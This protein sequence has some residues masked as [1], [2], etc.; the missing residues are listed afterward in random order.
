MTIEFHCPH[1]DKTLK[2]SEDKAGRQAKCPG[3]GELITVPQS[4][5][6]VMDA[7]EDIS[8]LVEVVDDGSATPPPVP[9][10]SDATKACPFCGEQIRVA[11]TKCRY[12]GEKFGQPKERL[13][14][15]GEL[16]P[17]PPGEAISEAWQIFTDR[18][19]ISIGVSVVMQIITSFA[20]LIWYVPLIMAGAMSDQGNDEIAIVAGGIAF[21]MFIVYA[22]FAF[23]LLSGYTNFL[24][25]LARGQ[26]AKIEDLFSGGRY[27][28]RSLMCTFLFVL[29]TY[30]GIILCIVPGVIVALMYFPYMYVIVDKDAL[31]ISS[32]GR[33]RA[34]S[35][36]NWG[37]ILLI[38][39][40]AFGCQLLGVVTCYVGLI[41]TTPFINLLFAVAYDK[42]S[43]QAP[44]GE[45]VV[46]S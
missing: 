10:D 9:P 17:F 37:S 26:D 19:G 4:Q 12:C 28:G 15:Y 7:V 39:L 35:Q 20:I 33:A 40:T 45:L 42:M 3:C 22:G 6:P 46:E 2:T 1:C 27:W 24:L 14:G 18:M 13:K 34:M 8:D 29:M 5:S 11:A 44:P 32:L 25:K 21:V 23:Y 30:L 38:M 43:R 16:R 41:F 31:G 36:G